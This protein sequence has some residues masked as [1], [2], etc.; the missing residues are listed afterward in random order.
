MCY[1][2]HSYNK[3]GE[4]K[5]LL[6]SHRAIN[7]ETELKFQSKPT[8]LRGSPPPCPPGPR[9]KPVTEVTGTVHLPAE[10]VHMEGTFWWLQWLV[11]GESREAP[12]RNV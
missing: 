6:R 3:L 4:K 7:A 9:R 12:E 11:P 10:D 2:L 1:M 8:R 5:M